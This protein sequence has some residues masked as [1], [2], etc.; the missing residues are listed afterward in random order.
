[1]HSYRLNIFGFPGN[2]AE[3]HQNLG[4]L[5]Q[6]FAV[7][8]VRDN[9]AVFGGDP[10]RI[11]AFGQSAGSGSL[12]YY[13]YA[14]VSNPILAGIVLQSGAIS[15]FAAVTTT[16]ATA[17]WFNATS[18][19]GCGNASSD[20]S[21]V[22]NCMRTIPFQAILGSTVATAPPSS[23]PGLPV[24]FIPTID[25]ISVFSDY[26]GRS[27][28]GN[29]AKV[30][31]LIGNNDYE[32][33]A[34]VPLTALQDK[35]YPQAFWDFFDGSVFDCPVAV[36]AS[37]SVQHNIP[38]WRYRWFGNFPNTKITSVPDSGAYHASELAVLFDQLPIRPDIP[39][40][41]PAEMSIGEYIRGAWTIFAKDPKTGLK[42]YGWP[43]YTPNTT[44]LVRVAFN[45][46]TGPNPAF[47]ALYDRT[48]P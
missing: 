18:Y 1:L 46:Q 45:N 42:F 40:S 22:V 4:L 11:V 25:N 31:L 6:R 43:T 20:A 41:T 47:P 17:A 19:L 34:F 2:P 16:Q 33:G 9:I 13:S 8:W 3:P 21:E 28:A 12:D 48:C 39:P 24:S 26:A 38:T 35:F 15:G 30:P 14:Y 36:R 5:D 29:F 32:A 7:E 27:A 37:I 44:S 10:N 23:I